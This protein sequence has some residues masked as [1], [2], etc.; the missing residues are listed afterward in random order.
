MFGL[1]KNIENGLSSGLSNLP[2]KAEQS[3]TPLIPKAPASHKVRTII[4]L[5]V[6]VI[7]FL[8]LGYLSSSYT[9]LRD[10]QI[11]QA[12]EEFRDF[13]QKAFPKQYK[14]E[15][16]AIVCLDFFCKEPALSPNLAE[17]KKNV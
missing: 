17:I 13:L 11:R 8:S 9:R 14:S 7:I 5:I 16:F 12:T 4:I 10:P 6:I 3:S 15:E 2:P 1:P